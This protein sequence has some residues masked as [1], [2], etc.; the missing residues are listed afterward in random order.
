MRMFTLIVFVSGLFFV[1]TIS[2]QNQNIIVESQTNSDRSITIWANNTTMCSYSIRINFLSITGYNIQGGSNPYTTIA[3]PG[4]RPI[5]K[6]VQDKS[7]SMYSLNYNYTFAPGSSFRKAPSN[8]N[9]YLLP[10]MPSKSTMV[11]NVSHLNS[12]IGKEMKGD[13]F[14]INFSYNLG[15]T[16]CATRAGIIFEIDNNQKIGESKTASYS[17]ER[18]K[19]QIEHK[20]GTIGIYSILSP[21]QLLV[22]NGSFVLPGQPIAIFNK[23]AEKYNVLYSINYIDEALLRNGNLVEMHKTLPAHF[24]LNENA[25]AETL[26]AGNTYSGTSARPIIIE[27]LNKR[28][29]KKY[30]FEN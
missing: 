14:A 22:E 24:Y 21:I 23:A 3:T 2:A 5:C 26:N 15:D 11:S 6:L 20:D 1:Q 7:A 29:K 13:Y 17:Q 18:N 19:I 28:E 8:Y 9:H 30:G 25:N 16:I 10:I 4:N 27:E 12:I